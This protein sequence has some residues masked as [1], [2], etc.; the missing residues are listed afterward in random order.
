MTKDNL[1]SEALDILNKFCEIN[2]IPMPK[3]S[4]IEDK[5]KRYCGYYEHYSSNIVVFTNKCATPAIN[6]GFKWSYPHYFVDKTILGVTC[7]EFGH[8]VHE[9]LG[10]PNMGKLGNK[11]TG[12][13][14]NMFERFAESIKLFLTNPDLLKQYNPKR[15]DFLT[16][17]LKL[18]PVYTTDWKTQLNYY[19]DVNKKYTTACENRINSSKH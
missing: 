4:L 12:Y 13:E 5:T 17:K 9:Y 2:N 11:I 19:G 10:H 15:Y 1:I 14:P 8:Y 7:H 6:P 16:N 3:V 18:K